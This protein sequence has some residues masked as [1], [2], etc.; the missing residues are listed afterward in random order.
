NTTTATIADGSQVQHAGSVTVS[1]TTAENTDAT[2][3]DKLTALAIAGA[4]ASKVSVAGA[5]AVGISTSSSTAS[6]GDNVVVD[7]GTGAVNVS[8][9]NTSKLSAKAFAASTGTG[10]VGIGASVATIYADHSLVASIGANDT[11]S[12][13]D[14]SVTALDKKFTTSAPSLTFDTNLKLSDVKSA[15]QNDALLGQDNYYAEAIGGATAGEA[16][17]SG[18]FAVMDF[19][20]TTKATAGQSLSPTG[21]TTATTLDSSGAVTIKAQSDLGST[22]LAGGV[23]AGNNVGVGIASAVIVSSGTVLAELEPN[24]EVLNAT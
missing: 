14:I 21:P 1:T 11:I 18:S 19:L 7:S 6:I 20:D 2:Y 9:D 24:A 16:A 15:A 3:A 17:I 23:A 13:G 5:L 12:G 4:S 22:A 10:Q 8:A